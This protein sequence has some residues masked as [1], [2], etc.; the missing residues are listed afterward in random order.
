MKAVDPLKR[1]VLRHKNFRHI[2]QAHA[3]LS[4]TA[5]EL[6]YYLDTN[7]I[8]LT[9]T[10]L[11]KKLRFSKSTVCRKVQMLK[12]SGVLTTRPNNLD[13]RK[14]EVL[15]T[16]QGAKRLEQARKAIREKEAKK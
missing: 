13:H 8:P 7:E 6:L 5:F 10:E 11:S 4:P 14:L 12:R 3:K 16:P 9:L 2:C 15:I 1:L